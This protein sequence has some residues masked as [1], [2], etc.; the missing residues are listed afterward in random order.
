QVVT[1]EDLALFTR[2]LATMLRA[3]I[4]IAV[5]LEFYSRGEP[6]YL[7][8]VATEVR[9]KME[10]GA[11]MSQAL[12]FHPRIFTP[13]FVGLIELGEHSSQLDRILDRLASMLERQR[14]LHKH[15]QAVL[16]YPIMLTIVTFFCAAVFVL[17]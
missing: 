13:S 17:Y 14:N 5:A 6:G 4:A 12:R 7:G 8:E 15:V 3:G 2:Q 10:E 16:T 1:V 9:R 11:R